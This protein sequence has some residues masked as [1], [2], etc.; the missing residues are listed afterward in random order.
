LSIAKTLFATL[1]KLAGTPPSILV[2]LSP[3]F[4]I[5]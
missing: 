2:N 5:N 4:A 3:K 1:C